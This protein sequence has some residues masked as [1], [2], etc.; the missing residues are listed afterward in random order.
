M[1][2]RDK[3]WAAAVVSVVFAG[4]FLFGSHLGQTAPD[5]AAAILD[6]DRQTYASPPCIINGDIEQE[7]IKN[8]KDVHDATASLVLEDYASLSTMGEA[9]AR[10][11]DR[12]W[13]VDERCSHADGFTQTINGFQWLIGYESRWTRQGDWRW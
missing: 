12:G 9:R 7:L 8:R 10:R 3:L 2:A 6:L 13:R 4:L 5:H 11:K 1:S